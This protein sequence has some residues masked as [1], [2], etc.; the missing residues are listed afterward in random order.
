MARSN[1][2]QRIYA[3]GKHYYADL[4][5]FADV[6]GKQEAL[7][8]P[9]KRFATKDYDLAIDLMRL[10]LNELKLAREGKTPTQRGD[11]RLDDYA[12]EHLEAKLAYRRPSTVE[13]DDR[14]LQNVR[15]FFA[16]KGRED[17]K[18]SEI[19]T[20]DLRR[21]IVWRRRQPGKRPG[22]RIQPQTILHE[23]HALSDVYNSAIGDEIVD[24]NPVAKLGKRKPTIDRDEPQ[25][26]EIGEATNMLKE[27][28]K[29]DAKPHPRAL[30]YFHPVLAT[31][32]L[33]G[34][35]GTEVF[36]L[37]VRDIDFERDIVHIRPNSWRK[38]K[39][40]KH[41]RTVP[42]WPQLRQILKAH[43]ERWD[44]DSGLLFPAE[45]GGILTDLS[46]SI[47]ATTAAAGID[48]NVTRHTFR[49]TYAATRMQT[50]DNGQPVSPYTVM[51][52]LGHRSLKLIEE[53]Y[54][55][56]QQ[57]RHRSSV[58]EYREVTVTPIAERRR[59]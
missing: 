22:T 35:R 37:E 17:I 25:W 36:G 11:P 3:K 2:V 59:A 54:G 13:R 8:P 46:G 41:R 42:L 44:C 10:R 58:V 7:I 19:T 20:G 33:T 1:D 32:L 14:A 23:L 43:V 26:L 4:R 24:D 9:G 30:R 49:H 34:G 56:L 48:K 5:D 57:I 28:A 55:H 40:V 16:Q 38:L 39:N 29:R 51:R 47:R 50:L 18:L 52:E 15:A 6:G 31:F 45:D 12:R 21:Y 27:A 53:S